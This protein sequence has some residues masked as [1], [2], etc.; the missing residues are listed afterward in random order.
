M[1]AQAVN[2]TKD[3]LALSQQERAALAHRLLESLEE[4]PSNDPE[5]ADAWNKE[6]A[7]RVEQ[8]KSGTAKGRPAQDVLAE[9]RARYS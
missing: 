9:I 4:S 6:I 5:I 8:I 7:R 2:I 3:A 1:S